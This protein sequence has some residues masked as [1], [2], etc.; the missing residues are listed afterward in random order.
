MDSVKQM[1]QDVK[2]YIE[3]A[4]TKVVKMIHA[5]LEADAENSWWDAMPDKI[6]GDVEAAIKEADNGEIIPHAEIQKR[7]FA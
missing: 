7:L 5:M 1:R 4:D 2:K 6:K 3:T